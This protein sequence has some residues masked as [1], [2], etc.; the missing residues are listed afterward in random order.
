MLLKLNI[1]REKMLA[2]ALL[3]NNIDSHYDKHITHP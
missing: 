2:G 3:I 1:L